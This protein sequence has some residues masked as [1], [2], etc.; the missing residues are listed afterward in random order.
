MTPDA[1]LDEMLADL[2]P[3]VAWPST[4]NVVD[5]VLQPPVSPRRGPWR[6]L[7]TWRPAFA[8]A[9]VATLVLAAAV[10]ALAFGLPGLRIIVT[11]SLP[12]SAIAPALGERLDLGDPTTLE[13]AAG[14]FGGGLAVPAAAGAPDETYAAADGSIVWLVY[15]AD[16]ALPPLA[17]S[18]VG[19]LVMEVHGTVDSEQIDKLVVEGRNTVTAV[20]VAGAPGYWIEGE[21]HLLRYRDPSGGTDEVVSRLV[22]DTLVWERDGILYRIESGLGARETLRLATSM[23]VAP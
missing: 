11:P 21:P 10:A 2:A 15:S 5:R 19:L 1:R 14:S 13:A 23:Q 3:D 22:G 6:L 17:G 16:D 18:D 8:I 4:P 9:V 12:P 7:R 20:S